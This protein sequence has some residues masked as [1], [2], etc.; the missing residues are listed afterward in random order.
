[1]ARGSSVPAAGGRLSSASAMPLRASIPAVCDGWWPT[2]SSRSPGRF[3]IGPTR[4][5]RALR[6]GRRL[7]PAF[8]TPCSGY[9]SAPPARSSAVSASAASSILTSRLRPCAMP[10]QI[11]ETPGQILRAEE[12]CRGQSLGQTVPERY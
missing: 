7:V 5:D 3:T 2:P 8:R 9:S 12:A 10:S 4:P 1:M 6:P 11:G